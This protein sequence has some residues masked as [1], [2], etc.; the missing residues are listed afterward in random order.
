M[1]VRTHVRCIYSRKG[2]SNRCCS[3]LAKEARLDRL[4]RLNFTGPASTRRF[5]PTAS[6]GWFEKIIQANVLCPSQPR[7]R[8][9]HRQTA[10][11]SRL[12]AKTV[13]LTSLRF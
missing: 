10:F 4:M 13:L 3:Y 5:P 9:V 6:I 11:H 7:P 8:E 12:F 1:E 2:S